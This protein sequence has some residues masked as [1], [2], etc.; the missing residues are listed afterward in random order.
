MSFFIH[1]ELEIPHG[2]NNRFDISRDSPGGAYH[3]LHRINTPDYIK[4]V[5][6]DGQKYRYSL[7]HLHHHLAINKTCRQI[8]PGIHTLDDAYIE[9][10]KMD[11]EDI[12]TDTCKYKITVFVIF[13][14]HNSIQQ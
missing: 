14:H 3:S 8:L 2:N 10:E 12:D 1:V 9:I 11:Q 6:D 7:I 5:T 4:I 13:K